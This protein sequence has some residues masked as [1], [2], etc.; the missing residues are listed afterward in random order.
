MIN[1]YDGRRKS[2]MDIFEICFVPITG[3]LEFVLIIGIETRILRLTKEEFGYL[4]KDCCENLKH[5]TII[6]TNKYHVE[7]GI[8]YTYTKHILDNG[9]KTLKILLKFY[10]QNQEKITLSSLQGEIEEIIQ[11]I[12][13]DIEE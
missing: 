10:G 5:K 2:A 4:I 13:R 11:D 9:K 1:K 6:K 12:G 3:T 8:I 7:D